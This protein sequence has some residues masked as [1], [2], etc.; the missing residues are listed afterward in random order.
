MT[1]IAKS[2]KSSQV[3]LRSNAREGIPLR[4]LKIHVGEQTQRIQATIFRKIE[5]FRQKFLII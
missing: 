5:N 3:I 1:K 2:F 4:F